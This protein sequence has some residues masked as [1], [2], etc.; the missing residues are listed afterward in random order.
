E[1]LCEQIG[2]VDAI[3]KCAG[4][5]EL[6]AE[7]SSQIYVREST[8][9]IMIKTDHRRIMRSQLCAIAV[10]VLIAAVAGCGSDNSESDSSTAASSQADG[11]CEAASGDDFCS[12]FDANGGNATLVGPLAFWEPAGNVSDALDERL[13]AMG[14]IEPPDEIAEYWN[15]VKSF[16]DELKTA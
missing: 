11:H 7:E 8:G 10:A 6:T 5:F 12:Q 16:Y 15:D 2:D 13:K 9:V 14:D 1:A 4:R 3:R